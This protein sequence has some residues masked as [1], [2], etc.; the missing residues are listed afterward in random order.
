MRNIGHK[1]WPA[2]SHRFVQSRSS[3]L[4]HLLALGAAYQLGEALNEGAHRVFACYRSESLLITDRRN[5]YKHA[6]S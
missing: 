2:A 5:E 4:A 3:A 6:C 1:S